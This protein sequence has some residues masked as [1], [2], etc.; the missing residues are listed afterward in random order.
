M[1]PI[2]LGT[3]R[4]LLPGVEL[5]NGGRFSNDGFAPTTSAFPAA[6]VYDRRSGHG[7]MI[8][9]DGGADQTFTVSDSELSCQ[10]AIELP[11]RSRR[12]LARVH[13]RTSASGW[14]GAVLPAATRLRTTT[15]PGDA[16]WFREA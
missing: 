6:T 3:V 11:G 16:R 4:Q 10:Q 13:V 7:L 8:Y 15:P 5:R 14:R 12:T 1:V 9:G 2:E